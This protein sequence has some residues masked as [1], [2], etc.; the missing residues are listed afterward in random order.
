MQRK[1]FSYMLQWCTVCVVVT[2][3][4]C[5]PVI[6]L[7]VLYFSSTVCVSCTPTHQPLCVFLL[8]V[9]FFYWLQEDEF[10]LMRLIG[11]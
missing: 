5:V 3:V 8:R 4:V 10:M 2:F 6:I 7:Y 9:Y 1:T 11:L